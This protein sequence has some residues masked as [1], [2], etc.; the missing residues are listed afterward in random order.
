[1]PVSLL[2]VTAPGVTVLLSVMLLL[3]PLLS[4]VTASWKRSE[5]LASPL[6]K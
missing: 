2:N 6:T 1:M 3:A 4:K 5:L